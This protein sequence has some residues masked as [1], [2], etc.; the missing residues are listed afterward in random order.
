MKRRVGSF[1][2][3]GYALAGIQ[4]PY[5]RKKF[6]PG[7][8]YCKGDGPEPGMIFTDNNGPIVPCPVCNPKTDR[9]IEYER[10]LMQRSQQ[11]KSK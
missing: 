10:A 5:P 11:E 8:D 9:E 6:L 1:V 3:V 7:C 2:Q 4:T